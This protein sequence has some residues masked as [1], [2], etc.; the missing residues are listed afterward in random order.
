M[1]R[2]KS[3]EEEETE[4]RSQIDAPEKKIHL[5]N[6]QIVQTPISHSTLKVFWKKSRLKPTRISA[7][8]TIS[9]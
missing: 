3:T 5:K 6:R 2:L 1:Y 8:F 9:V 4:N 7:S